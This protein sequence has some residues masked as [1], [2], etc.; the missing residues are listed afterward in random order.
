[1]VHKKPDKYTPVYCSLWRRLLSTIYD[2]VVIL[3]LLMIASAIALPIGNSSKFA[4]RDFWFTAWL[5]LVCFAYL[6]ACW[7]YAGMTV[8]MRAWRLQLI[9]ADKEMISWPM[10]FIR[11]G[12]AIVSLGL[13]GAGFLWSLADR[14]NRTWHDLAANTLLLKN[15]D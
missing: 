14:K 8:G 4:L 12:T 2:G 9:T 11:F 3:G 1:M 10:C 13:F 5:T 15:V 6:G 7:H